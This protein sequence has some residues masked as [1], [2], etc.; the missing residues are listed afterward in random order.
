MISR[1]VPP[2][3]RLTRTLLRQ[4]SVPHLSRPEVSGLSDPGTALGLGTILLTY[5]EELGFLTTRSR[6]EFGW[7]RSSDLCTC[8]ALLTDMH[9]CS[10]EHTSSVGG[11]KEDG[12]ETWS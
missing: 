8:S 4:G 7:G 1:L 9:L 2:A 12:L 11:T 3:P 6:A 5:L 10:S